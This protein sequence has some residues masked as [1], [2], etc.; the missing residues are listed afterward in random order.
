MTNCQVS[1]LR[2]VGFIGNCNRNFR[3]LQ[4][5]GSTLRGCL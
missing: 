5:F 2:V 4:G 1:S 3:Y